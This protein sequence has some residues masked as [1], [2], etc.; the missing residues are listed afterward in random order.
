MEFFDERKEDSGLAEFDDQRRVVER[1][2]EEQDG[3]VAI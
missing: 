2:G 1:R 3:V